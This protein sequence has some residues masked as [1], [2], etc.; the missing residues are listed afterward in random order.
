MKESRGDADLLRSLRDGDQSAYAI[1][2]ERHIGAALRYAHRIYPARAEDLA[3]ETFVAI[4]QQVT[5]TSKGPEF[6]FRS[7]LKAVIR[8]TAIRWRWPPSR[9]G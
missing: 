5:T 1:L 2:W 6:A 7:Y 3:S 9:S 8:N 4:Y